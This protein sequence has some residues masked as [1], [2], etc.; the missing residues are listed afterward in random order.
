MSH[1]HPTSSSGFLVYFYECV[2]LSNVNFSPV[3][4]DGLRPGISVF[5]FRYSCTKHCCTIN[6]ANTVALAVCH[7]DYS[8]A[9]RWSI[10]SGN[11]SAPDLPPPPTPGQNGFGT[12]GMHKAEIQNLGLCHR[13]KTCLSL[14]KKIVEG[15]F[16]SYWHF[17]GVTGQKKF[18]F[19]L[20]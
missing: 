7:P 5:Q 19:V 1:F 14:G 13:D 20:Q 8:A 2:C 4:Q 10:I 15:K 18:V 16:S 12:I 6:T 3:Y 9:W 11:N 17:L